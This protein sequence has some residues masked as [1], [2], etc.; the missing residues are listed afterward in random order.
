[1]FL[2]AS[3]GVVV[4]NGATTRPT[5]LLRDADVAMFAAKELGRGRVE[6]FDDSD[7]RARGRAGSRSRAALRRALVRGEF[8]VHYQPVVRFDRPR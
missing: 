5:R 1:M 3:V 8:R 4:S 2:G 7:A 6:V